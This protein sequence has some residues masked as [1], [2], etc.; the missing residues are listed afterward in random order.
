MTGHSNAGACLAKSPSVHTG[1][2]TSTEPSGNIFSR[3]CALPVT[4]AHT[5]KY[6][7]FVM[8]LFTASTL[9]LAMFGL[10]SQTTVAAVVISNVGSNERGTAKQ[11]P[12][13][14]AINTEDEKWLN[15]DNEHQPPENYYTYAVPEQVVP[16]AS[17][18]AFR[19]CREPSM[20]ALTFD[21][22]PFPTTH[23]I[24][25]VLKEEGVKATFFV[26][27]F[28]IDPKCK[29]RKSNNA[30]SRWDPNRPTYSYECAQ[31]AEFMLQCQNALRR[32]HEEGHE[33]GSHTYFHAFTPGLNN[34]ELR[35]R[36]SELKD[37]VEGILGKGTL[38]PIL[39]PPYIRTSYRITR[40]ASTEGYVVVQANVHLKEYRTPT[41]EGKM[42]NITATRWENALRWHERGDP[43]MSS[44]VTYQH[45]YV[46]NAPLVARELIRSARKAGMRV[47]TAG[48][49]VGLVRK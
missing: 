35:A 48:E 1:S 32:M 34:D 23:P 41:L 25:D 42:S 19:S 30:T 46:A 2:H 13:Q 11:F 26:N 14:N 29:E 8:A 20:L 44:M 24:L 38:S 15:A 5:R 45:D 43:G 28:N 16:K 17:A 37:A 49:C 3:T 6:W 31:D 21:D 9:W 40:V 12:T 10:S 18:W 33:I 47:V 22:G 27:G 39:R 7:G 36:L 4:S